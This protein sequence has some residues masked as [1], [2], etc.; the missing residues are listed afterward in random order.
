MKTV[1]QWL[2]EYGESHKN[3]TNKFI[4]W[5]C[6]PAIF[7]SITGLLYCIKLPLVINGLSVNV[8]MTVILLITL[9]YLRLSVLL[10]TGMFLFGVLCLVVCFVIDI[11]IYRSHFG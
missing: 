1:N 8:A 7:F 6:V 3:K 11:Y 2:T 4:H 5:I 9:Y 10:G